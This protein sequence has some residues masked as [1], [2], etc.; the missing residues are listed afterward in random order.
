M[1]HILTMASENTGSNE[2][3]PI[4]PG[5]HRRLLGEATENAGK[6]D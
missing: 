4:V 5:S 6:V 2:P 1:S 3:A